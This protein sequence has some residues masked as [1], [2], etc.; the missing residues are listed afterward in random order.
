MLRTFVKFL[1]CATILLL[2]AGSAAGQALTLPPSGDNQHAIATQFIGPVEL[3]IDYNSPDVTSPTGEDRTGKIW[4]GLVPYG[5]TNLGFGSCTEC[6]WRAGANENT[7]FSVSHDV[8]IEGAPLAAGSYGL[9]MIPG[10]DEWTIIFSN[11]STSWGSFFYDESEDA[12]RVTVE[13]R[14][15]PYHEWLSYEF[16][17]RDPSQ[18]TAALMWENLAVPFT[19]TVPDMAS[20]YMESIRKELRNAPGFQWQNWNAAAQYALQNGYEEE[21]LQWAHTAVEQPFVG[22]E[23]MTTLSTLSQALEANGQATAAKETLMKAVN[24]PTAD[25]LALHG[26]GRQLVTQGKAALAMEVFRTNYERFDGA[27]PTHVGMARGYSALGEYAKAA[28]HA[29]KALEQ[30]PDELNRQN[31]ERLIEQLDKGEAIN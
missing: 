19:I 6:P 10:K 31:L 25:T 9:H 5:L 20:V 12:L 2:A 30:A 8:E 1:W 17:D 29:R 4:G 15:N 16:I 26:L 3:S 27:W 24:H 22:Q 21:A 11:N 23:N 18:A 13:P 14:S 28:E 7:V